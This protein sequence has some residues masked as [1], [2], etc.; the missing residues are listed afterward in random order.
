VDKSVKGRKSVNPIFLETKA[1]YTT[2][3]VLKEADFLPVD[4][5]N[6]IVG[7]HDCSFHTS[8]PATP[9]IGT[10]IENDV[11]D[12]L[13]SESHAAF[14]RAAM[15]DDI[16]HG[17]QGQSGRLGDWERWCEGVRV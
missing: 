15:V 5:L 9:D 1:G 13:Q 8:K 11:D 14:T 10:T 2:Y 3:I 12:D 4:T 6:I 17:E 7:E 16:S